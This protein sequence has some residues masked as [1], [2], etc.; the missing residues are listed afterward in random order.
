MFTENDKNALKNGHPFSEL[1]N[2]RKPT[3]LAIRERAVSNKDLF[4]LA[5]A[6]VPLDVPKLHHLPFL[7]L[8]P[9]RFHSS[10]ASLASVSLLFIPHLLNDRRRRHDSL[11]E[12]S[13]NF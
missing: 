2:V 6:P 10:K 1:A 11:Q 5:E 7:M 9:D 13:L 8:L 4:N 3:S 12:K